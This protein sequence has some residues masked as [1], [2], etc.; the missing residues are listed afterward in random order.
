MTQHR[1]PRLRARDV[2][3]VFAVALI[4][5]LTLIAIGAQ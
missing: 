2:L 4:F 3:G 1:H 5:W